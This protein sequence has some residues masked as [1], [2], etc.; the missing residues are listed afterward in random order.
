M[1]IQIL[2][3][4]LC[5]CAIAL[6]IFLLTACSEQIEEANKLVGEANALVE[7]SKKFAEQGDAKI[8]EMQAKDPKTERAELERLGREG[9]ELYR[10]NAALS[11]DAASKMEQACQMN[12]PEVHKKYWSL[13][14]QQ[15]QKIAERVN[16]LI[17]LRELELKRASLING[18]NLEKAEGEIA[19]LGAK[20]DALGKEAEDLKRQA[21][22]IQQENADVFERQ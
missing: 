11:Q 17:Q 8:N 12:V 3:N 13:I 18:K 19:Q 7:K 5:L 1:N 4:V 9:A 10:Q 20:I 16:T 21:E 14:A 22:K 6:S 2:R 15:Y